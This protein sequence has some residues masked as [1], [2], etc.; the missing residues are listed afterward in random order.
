MRL[1][2]ERVKAQ[3]LGHLHLSVGTKAKQNKEVGCS[4]QFP[5]PTWSG[6]TA[7]SGGNWEPSVIFGAKSSWNSI[8]N[9]VH[10]AN[11]ET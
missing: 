10:N 3:N 6:L 7:G 11:A 4:G 2:G 1:S 5:F 8:F 9:G